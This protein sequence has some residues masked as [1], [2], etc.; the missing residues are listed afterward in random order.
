MGHGD[1][2]GAI[3]EHQGFQYPVCRCF[4]RQLRLYDTALCVSLTAR[5][6]ALPEERV[7]RVSPNVRSPTASR[8]RNVSDVSA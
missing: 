7:L 2:D 1:G 5:P 8:P 6:G 4:L 3:F